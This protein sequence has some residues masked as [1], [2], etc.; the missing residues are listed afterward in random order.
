MWPQV[1]AIIAMLIALVAAW[2]LSLTEPVSSDPKLSSVP[3]VL[4]DRWTAETDE[5]PARQLEILRASEVLLRHYRPLE[6]PAVATSGG[7]LPVSLFVAYYE[8][9]RTGATYHSPRHCLPGAGWQITS[10][11]RV[12]VPSPYGGEAEI[13]E[14]LIQSGLAKQ[15][16]LY[17][18]QDRGR[19]VASE[20]VAKAYLMWDSLTKHRSDGALVR[21][22]VVVD[23]D[24]AEARRRALEFVEDMWRPLTDALTQ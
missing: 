23:D 19:I 13:N 15:L 12:T 6:P 17:W 22:S 11:N 5:L 16:I 4:A 14:A 20:Y 10:L 1:F 21:V 18:Y 24:V 8:S 2:W 7:Q 9:Q 3:M